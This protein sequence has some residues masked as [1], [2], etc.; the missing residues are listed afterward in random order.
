MRWLR[1]TFHALGASFSL[2]LSL[3]TGLVLTALTGIL[4]WCSS[5]GSLAQA[6]WLL[7]PLLPAGQTLQ[8]KD[9]QGSVARGGHIGHVLWKK[10]PLSVE[11]QDLQMAWEWQ[12]LLQGELRLTGLQAAA[13]RVEDRGPSSTSPFS[14][15]RLPLHVDAPFRV[16][17]VEWAGAPVWT[18]Q[19]L[20][21]HYRFDGSLH[22]LE[23]VRFKM[24]AGS[25]QVDASLQAALPGALAV[26][27]SGSV[28]TTVQQHDVTLL[29]GAKLA[30]TL[31]GKNASLQL[32]LDLQPDPAQRS[33]HGAQAHLQAQLQPA[34]PQPLQS[35]NGQWS[36]LDLSGLWPQAPQTSLSGQVRVAPQGA[37]WTA[38]L[39]L[40]NR[41]EGP[42]SQ[43]RLPLQSALA[44]L[45]YRDGQWLV[46]DLQAALAGG[47]L[48]AQGSYSGSPALWTAKG[49]VRGLDWMRVDPRWNVGAV[50]GEFSVRQTPSGTAFEVQANSMSKGAAGRM[51]A[52]AKGFWK[53]PALVVE[54]VS[55]QSA[56]AQV[57]GQL[58]WNTRSDAAQLQLQTSFPGGQGSINGQIS[59]SAGQGS[60]QWQIKDA[61]AFL[62][63]MQTLPGFGSQLQGLV[64]QGAAEISARWEG[65]WQNRGSGLK[66]NASLSSKRLDVQ[67]RYH[68]SDL[69]MDVSGTLAVLDVALRSDV[70]WGTSR[71]AL[72][73]Q[74]QLAQQDSGDLRVRMTQLKASLQDGLQ[75]VPWSLQLQQPL[76]LDWQHSALAQSVSVS[77]GT[78]RMS[79]PAP[80]VAQ[81]Q[82]E[83]I[84][85]SQ[86]GSAASPGVARWSSRG[87]LQGV[88]LA[89][90][91]A[92]GQ[93]RLANLGLRGDVVL[94]GQ[95]DA[96]NSG[97]GLQLR[98]RLQRSNGDLQLLGSDS[99]G[100][101]LP[102][103][104]RDAH[105]E[106]EIAGEAVHANLVWASDAGGNAQVDFSTRIS[107]GE[108]GTTWP[109]DAPL[110]GSVQANLPRVGAWSLFAPVGWRINGTLEANAT[111]SGTRSKPSWKG[112]LQARDMSI[113]SVVDGID[114]SAGSMHLLIDGQHMDIAEF[115]LSGAGG[116][117]GGQLVVGGTLDWLP[118]SAGSPLMNHV[119][120]ALVA[121]ARAFRVTAKPDQR[122]VV[123]GNLS[124]N[125]LDAN[126]QIRGALE[127]DQ[128]MIVLPEDTAPRL[129]SDVLVKRS[130]ATSKP[131]TSASSDPA[132]KVARTVVPDIVVTL[133]PGSNFLIQGRG[134]STRL[135]GILVLK[136]QGRDAPPRLTGELRTVNGTYRAYGQR[137]TIEEG[138]LRFTG[139]YDNPAL[140]IRAIRPNLT[141]V[142]GVHVSGTA[143]L[144]VVRL[145]S[146]P[147]L[148]DIEKLSWLVLGRSSA[149]GG[150][151]TVILQQAALALF[152]G[153]GSSQRENLVSALGLD[154]VSLGQTAVTNLDG[155]AGTETTVKV[156]KRLSRDFYVVYERS[157]AGTLGTLYV[158]YD[159]SRRFTLRGESG[160]TTGVDLIFTTRYD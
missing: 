45:Q 97:N 81:L 86:R 134:L 54:N 36:A 53:S 3:V 83:P 127:A 8:V 119:R 75:S 21:G 128:A 110:Q 146:D 66:L 122:L 52:L 90:L 39:Q 1:L 158:F 106:V 65:G 144:P 4:V 85:W 88:P 79:G 94:G 41:L 7:G 77:A 93:T 2:V 73:S 109:A 130:K 18:V 108:S 136:A 28:A 114:L 38:S 113:R 91:E 5:E 129:G 154:E 155:T 42:W 102:A 143:Q 67:D 148:S 58:Q 160:I 19:K 95:W 117:S 56:Q 24:A 101:S 157:L 103:G 64:A 92:L 33:L 112:S 138:T 153:S 48:H 23:D 151:E 131:A 10:G 16:D 40:Q 47:T 145:Y 139:A 133:D 25:Y 15:I 29:A 50:D 9:T 69:Q 125:L 27:A 71:L 80:G 111:L 140:D 22:R 46:S 121:N 96:S 62:P 31:Y 32:T 118:A 12:A 13:L 11:V 59:A 99:T 141:Q 150:A 135:A 149:N 26:R 76:T 98:A 6:L 159:L 55:L 123:S 44:S 61:G 100:G 87:S 17:S 30:G 74:A 137:L 68:L 126:L 152:A 51:Q 63:W 43:N 82:W 78:L 115:R 14:E 124:A 34:Q 116:A 107:S 89:W 84:G 37:G 147:E 20:Q 70:Q 35:A 49:T 57:N 120:M 132:S 72:Q 156:G 105:V 60:S 104:L 142:V